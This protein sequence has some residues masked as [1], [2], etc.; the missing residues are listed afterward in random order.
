MTTRARQEEKVPYS[1]DMEIED[2]ACMHTPIAVKKAQGIRKI[3]LKVKI[4]KGDTGSLNQESRSPVLK[5]T[6]SPNLG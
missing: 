2:G 1:R 4:V 6:T 3:A 5:M